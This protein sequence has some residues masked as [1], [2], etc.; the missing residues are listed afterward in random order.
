MHGYL[1]GKKE[2]DE[3]LGA[4]QRNHY[5]GGVEREYRWKVPSY[6][7][8]K[9]ILVNKGT[10]ITETREEAMCAYLGKMSDGTDA[11]AFSLAKGFRSTSLPIN[12]SQISLRKLA[13]AVALFSEQI[14]LRPLN[15]YSLIE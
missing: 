5:F 2:L 9:N 8:Q 14:E 15:I 10:V 1:G 13:D 7:K 12:P 4:Y 11:H 3:R 6:E